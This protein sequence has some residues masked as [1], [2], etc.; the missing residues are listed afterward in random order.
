MSDGIIQYLGFPGFGGEV[1][2]G[3]AALQTTTTLVH[4]GPAKLWE[5]VGSTDRPRA[6]GSPF[7]DGCG[8]L[9]VSSVATRGVR[10]SP[11]LFETGK[12]NSVPVTSRGMHLNTFVQLV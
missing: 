1:N 11:N 2:C 10:S 4:P 12:H 3:K 7:Y 9:G 6:A 5:R 8:R